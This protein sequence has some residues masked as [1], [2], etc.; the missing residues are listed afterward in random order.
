MKKLKLKPGRNERSE[1]RRPQPHEKQKG[2]RVREGAV[3][4]SIS[5]GQWGPTRKGTETRLPTCST[6]LV[7]GHGATSTF[8]GS[9][10][11]H[12]APVAFSFPRIVPLVLSAW[13]AMP[14]REKRKTKT[15][16]YYIHRQP[17][18][19]LP[20]LLCGQNLPPPK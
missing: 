4:T 14:R 16:K 17:V 5:R 8:S 15:K 1:S 2:P 10:G 6:C 13:A 18:N 3:P 9:G 19:Y 7:D 11:I 12:S 20:L